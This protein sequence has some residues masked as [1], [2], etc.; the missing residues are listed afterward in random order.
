MLSTII[1]ALIIGAVAGWIA[2]LIVRGGGFGL[3]QDFKKASGR[4][5]DHL[6]GGFCEVLNTQGGHLVKVCDHRGCD[7]AVEYV[8]AELVPMIFLP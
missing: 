1:I 2:G 6:G 7:A 4:D 3:I 8:F 5:W